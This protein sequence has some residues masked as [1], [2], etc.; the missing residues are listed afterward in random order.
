MI[1]C[2]F[3]EA[4]LAVMGVEGKKTDGAHKQSRLDHCTRRH[5]EIR[6]DAQDI[7][8]ARGKDEHDGD[9]SASARS[10]RVERASDSREY[11]GKADSPSQLVAIRL[12][13]EQQKRHGRC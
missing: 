4:L 10:E 5:T 3:V 8:D 12:Y 11:A 2:C 6:N 1:G 9:P 7:C 13:V